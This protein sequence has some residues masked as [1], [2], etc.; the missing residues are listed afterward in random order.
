MF[1]SVTEEKKSLLYNHLHWHNWTRYKS[2]SN[3]DN[4]QKYIT[5]VEHYTI[6]NEARLRPTR[7]EPLMTFSK[8]F[9]TVQWTKGYKGVD[10]THF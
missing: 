9:L 6:L 8:V 7:L 10:Q 1:N 2:L 4:V 3:L 5:V